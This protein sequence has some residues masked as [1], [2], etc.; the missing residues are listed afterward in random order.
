MKFL[1]KDDIVGHRSPWWVQ[2]EN[3]YMKEVKGRIIN[4]WTTTYLQR[5]KSKQIA[6]EPLGFHRSLGC[7]ARVWRRP[8]NMEMKE[9]ETAVPGPHHAG[10]VACGGSG[11][12]A[13]LPGRRRHRGWGA[14][15]PGRGEEV[16]GGT[17]GFRSH[18]GYGGE[19][20]APPLWGRGRGGAVGGSE[21]EREGRRCRQRE[22]GDGYRS[23]GRERGV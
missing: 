2:G 21:R 11:S 7:A 3:E 22:R 20:A 13:P 18:G 16:E 12:P 17:L 15:C 8:Q 5:E 23:R 10:G 6:V 19:R 1:G 4:L 9:G 14:P